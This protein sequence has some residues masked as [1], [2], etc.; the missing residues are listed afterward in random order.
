M[1]KNRNKLFI[2]LKQR[3]YHYPWESM[4]W[5]PPFIESFTYKYSQKKVMFLNKDPA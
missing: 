5:V 3:K 2:D 1:K 4:V